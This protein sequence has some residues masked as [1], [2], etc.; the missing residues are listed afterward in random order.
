LI[1][2]NDTGRSAVNATHLIANVCPYHARP[3]IAG[4]LGEGAADLQ[5]MIPF[6]LAATS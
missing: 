3:S 6:L 2:A 5:R 1:W 4:L